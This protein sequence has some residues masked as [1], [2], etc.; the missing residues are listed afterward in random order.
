[1]NRI[2]RGQRVDNKITAPVLK[3]PENETLHAQV[4][5]V[6]CMVAMCK[7]VSNELKGV[8]SPS[9]SWT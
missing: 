2:E 1:M 5:S 4:I 8:V 7:A 9:P 3:L 6:T